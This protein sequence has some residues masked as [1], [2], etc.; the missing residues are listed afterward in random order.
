M[1]IYWAVMLLPALGMISATSVSP[2]VNKTAWLGMLSLWVGIIGF[3]HEVGCD[4]EPY[5]DYFS[6]AEV[7]FVGQWVSS[8]VH[9]E[10]AYALLNLIAH[11]ADLGIYFV[12]LVCGL[13]TVVGLAKF[14]SWTEKSWLSWFVLT[15]YV[16]IVVG[17][18][19]TR[20]SVALALFAWG[21]TYLEQERYRR[22]VMLAVLAMAFHKWAGI[23][24]LLGLVTQARLLPKKM[25]WAVVATAGTAFVVFLVSGIFHEARD[26]LYELISA[27][28]HK[29]SSGTIARVTLAS[30]ASVVLLLTIIK[31]GNRHIVNPVWSWM[32]GISVLLIPLAATGLMTTIVDRLSLYLGPLQPYAWA[33]A[34]KSNIPMLSSGIITAAVVS[35]YMAIFLVWFEFSAHSFCWIPYNNVLFLRFLQ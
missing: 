17:L 12:N 31:S 21:L 16:L 35:I 14:C 34:S 19:Y 26:G 4:W 29:T 23:F 32:A 8:L 22:Y 11:R 18:G 30:L 28:K 25:V 7:F 24:F 33:L 20:Q 1:I 27:Y 5:M 9:M 10:P 6:G 3:R 2:R 13:L 15:P